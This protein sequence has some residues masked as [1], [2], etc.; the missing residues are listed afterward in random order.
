MQQIDRAAII[1][2]TGVIFLASLSQFTIPSLLTFPFPILLVDCEEHSS[3]PIILQHKNKDTMLSIEFTSRGETKQEGLYFISKKSPLR[4]WEEKNLLPDYTSRIWILDHVIVTLSSSFPLLWPCYQ[5]PLDSISESLHYQDQLTVWE[6]GIKERIPFKNIGQIFVHD[7]FSSAMIR[8]DKA[9]QNFNSSRETWSL[10]GAALDQEERKEIASFF[11]LN[12]AI[13]LATIQERSRTI[14]LWSF[15]SPSVVHQAS[16]QSF[17]DII[18]CHHF[19]LLT[20]RSSSSDGLPGFFVLKETRNSIVLDIFNITLPSSPSLLSSYQNLFPSYSKRDQ[21]RKGDFKFLLHQ[22]LISICW[23]RKGVVFLDLS[24]LDHPKLVDTLSHFHFLSSPVEHRV[25][26]TFEC[27]KANFFQYRKQ[28]LYCISYGNR[29]HQNK[30]CFEL[31]TSHGVN[32]ESDDVL[33]RQMTAKERKKRKTEEVAST[34]AYSFPDQQPKG[35]KQTIPS[36]IQAGALHTCALFESGE[37]RCWG[38]SAEG[39]LG[40]GTRYPMPSLIPQGISFSDWQPQ[41]NQIIT[42]ISSGQEHMCAISQTFP[43]SSSSIS[44]LSTSSN[45]SKNISKS[46]QLF[47]W[48]AG[49]DGRLGYGGDRP[50]GETMSP[51]NVGPIR[52]AD[53]V[54]LEVSCGF[55]HTCTLVYNISKNSSAVRCWGSASFDQLGSG[56]TVALKNASLARDIDIGGEPMK[57]SLGAYHTCVLLKTGNVKCWG[58]TYSGQTGY[59]DLIL[60]DP[61]SFLKIQ[62]LPS[63][64][65]PG[66]M[67]VMS[68]CSGSLHNCALLDDKQVYCWGSNDRGQLGISRQSSRKL[69]TMDRPVK[70]F[71]SS[72]SSEVVESLHCG[73]THTCVVFESKRFH[74]WGDN[75]HRQLGNSFTGPHLDRPS[76]VQITSL[77][78]GWKLSDLLVD[79]LTPV[80]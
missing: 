76:S 32:K 70:I 14:S 18:L 6:V 19:N 65:T 54:P 11:M 35:F 9:S 41:E 47:C 31:S 40:Y 30:H 49:L 37:V 68:M 12:N 8:S 57:L 61:R 2:A 69:K 16:I 58:G 10:R 24:Q 7:L 64:P 21:V 53:A 74:C 34:A 15:S 26:Y 28:T 56:L 60:N 55:Y 45:D 13:I 71:N 25:D 66:N 48:G 73:H 1:G 50:I 77:P 17:D 42:Q 38:G 20:G 29:G 44:S 62:F 5:T 79:K 3:H 67:K 22:R 23:T 4:V 39:V 59:S 72:S 52:L 51:A 43:S 75:S 33:D 46:N 36:V 63:V 27:S 80:S 78:P